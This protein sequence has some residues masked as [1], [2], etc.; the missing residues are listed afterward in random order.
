MTYID[1]NCSPSYIHLIPTTSEKYISFQIGSL[2]FLGSLQF[3]NA[4]LES[5]VQSLTKDGV[6][7]FQHTQIHFPG[8]D[9]VFQKGIYCNEYMDSRDKFE[10][11][12]L[13]PREQ[14]YCHLKCLRSRLRAC[15]EGMEWIHHLKSTPVRRPESDIRRP[16]VSRC[17]GKHTPY[18]T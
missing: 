14:F 18:V 13:P 8:C 9:L 15:S 17:I 2:R 4:S 12:K 11:T 6:D 10:E 1:R 3:L 5:V 16:T 7:K